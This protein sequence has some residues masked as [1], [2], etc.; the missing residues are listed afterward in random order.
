MSAVKRRPWRAWML[1]GVALLGSQAGGCS[2]RDKTLA[3]IK[4][5]R[6]DT[7]TRALIHLKRWKEAARRVT[8]KSPPARLLKGILLSR[9]L[10]AGAPQSLE[11][12]QV[13]LQLFPADAFSGG[14]HNDAKILWS[15]TTYQYLEALALVPIGDLFGDGN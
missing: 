8:K 4:L 13:G 15:D 3:P 12:L 5:G 11:E 7:E 2:C 1:A 9:A 14:A 10:L 6:G